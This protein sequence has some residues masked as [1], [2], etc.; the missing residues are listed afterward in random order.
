[1]N[2]LTRVRL[3]KN[4]EDILEYC[5]WTMN[6]IGSGTGRMVFEVSDELVLKV[7]KNE[8]GRR[9]NEVEFKLHNN[10]ICASIHQHSSNFDWCLMERVYPF[11]EN[12]FN[13]LTGT[14]YLDR[15]IWCEFKSIDNGHFTPEINKRIE[16]RYVSMSKDGW[17]EKMEENMFSSKLVNLMLSHD[18]EAGDL[19]RYDSWGFT[20]TNPKNPVLF[21]YGLSNAVWTECY[22]RHDIKIKVSGQEII[23]RAIEPL[24][25]LDTQFIRV[26]VN[27]K[28][29]MAEK[30][31]D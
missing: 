25:E 7:A 26:F 18:L 13:T 9:Q 14:T 22:K 11:D 20:K 24:D 6:L 10:D 17:L 21:D 30:V 3:I 19:V 2:H 12:T 1:M 8:A 5:G 27:N 16:A 29:V 31:I 15:M 23:C 28:S 4:R